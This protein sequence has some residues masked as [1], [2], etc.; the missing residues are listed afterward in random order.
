MNSGIVRLIQL[1]QP[2]IDNFYGPDK[3]LNLIE[4]LQ[5]RLTR[6]TLPSDVFQAECDRQAIRVINEFIQKRQFEVKAKQVDR[7]ERG[8]ERDGTSLLR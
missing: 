8:Y 4:I 2:L 5:V 7:Y 6:K 3:L 1:H